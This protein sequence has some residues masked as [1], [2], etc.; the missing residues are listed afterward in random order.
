M[1]REHNL[2]FTSPTQASVMVSIK[3][4]KLSFVGSKTCM[5]ATE[6]CAQQSLFPLSFSLLKNEEHNL[7]HK[8][9]EVASA[10]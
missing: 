2:F 6:D 10:L 5:A 1:S 4:G 3:S 8:S 7:E 9:Y